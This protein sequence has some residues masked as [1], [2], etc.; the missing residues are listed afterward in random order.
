[1]KKETKFSNKINLFQQVTLTIS[2]VIDLTI[3]TIDAYSSYESERSI[4][5]INLAESEGP[6]SI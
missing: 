1:M 6:A 2:N 3:F 4:K 5:P